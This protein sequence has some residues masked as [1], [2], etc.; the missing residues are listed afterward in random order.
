[1]AS[2]HSI[3][4]TPRVISPSPTPSESSSKDYFGPTTRSAARTARTKSP[5][6]ISEYK[7]R[8]GSG[9]GSDRDPE[10]RA[11][12]RSRSPA[13]EGGK[14]GRRKLSG[15]TSIKQ[16]GAPTTANKTVRR[17]GDQVVANGATNG[18]LSPQSANK[19]RWSW[20]EL[21]RSPSPLGLIPIH[22]TWRTFVS[23][24]AAIPRSTI[25][26]MTVSDPQA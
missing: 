19:S 5:P 8:D 12:T 3:P 15:L 25:S 20:R 18:H 23:N 21:S 16:S 14:D 4:T 10:K 9:S 22:K 6:P 2:Y 13:L 17:R 11:R 7:E 24:V 26:L 1:M